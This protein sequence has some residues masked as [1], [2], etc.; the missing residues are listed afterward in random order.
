MKTHL[1]LSPRLRLAAD[2]VPR[3]AKLCDVGTDHAYLPT[4]L[5]LEG[6]I[7]SAIASDLR[8]GPLNRAM[9]TAREYG[10]SGRMSFRL[11]NGLA[12]IAPEETD[13]VVIAGMGGETIA[14]ILNAAPWVRE[15]K[16]ELI[17]QPMSSQPE[18]R[19]WLAANGF[20]IR[21][22][23]LAREGDTLYVVMSVCAGVEEP[24][25]AAQVWAGRQ[26]RDPLRGAY[27]AELLEKLDRALAGMARST[28]PRTLARREELTLVR[29]GVA[30]MK[31]EWDAW[32]V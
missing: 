16:V 11:C 23:R 17:L 18:L 9:E 31:K 25:T 24:M 14:Q 7:S 13:A 21:E 32:Q 19:A 5:L 8:R 2:M 29:S 30:E 10:C 28:A 1:E 20:H 12:G 3:G 15:R 22:E 26:S 6:T 4:C 27:L